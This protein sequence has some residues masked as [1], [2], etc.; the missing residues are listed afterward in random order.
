MATFSRRNWQLCFACASLCA[1][2]AVALA[3]DIPVVRI[4]APDVQ[5]IQ[6]EDDARSLQGRP[7]RYALPNELYLSPDVAGAWDQP[8][9]TTRRWRVRIVS[10]GARSLNFGFD[11]YLMPAG[12]RLRIYATDGSAVLR[13]F[14][15]ADNDMHG[16]LWTPI[17]PSDDVTLEV[18]LPA[19]AVPELALQ[20]A[21]VNVGYRTLGEAARPR[22]QWCEIDVIC[23]EG[24][25]WRD[26]I[27]SVGLVSIGGSIVC[28]G[29][30]VNNTAEDQT[31]YFMTAHHCDLDINNAS[32]LVVYWNFESP[33][34]GQ[35]DGGSLGQWQSGSVWRA[36]YA[37]S[38][39]TLVELDDDPDPD[40]HI[41]FAGWDRSDVAPQTG[42]C[43]HHPDS[44]E[45]SISFE[46]HPCAISS[47]YGYSSPGNGSHIRVNDW[48]LGST[49]S[50]SSGSPL[51]N[52]NH[53]VVGQLHGGVA[54]CNNNE[55]DWYGRFAVSW[56]GGG[57]PTSRLRDWLDPLGTGQMTL[58]T[59]ATGPTRMRV[60]PAI[61]LEGAGYV[62]GPFEP[63]SIVYTVTNLG[64]EP[65]SFNV[66]ANRS[67]VSVSETVGLLAPGGTAPITASI[68][69]N[70]AALPLGTHSATV[71]FTNATSGSGNT[72]RGVVLTVGLSDVRYRFPMDVDPAWTTEGL[73]QFG[74]PAGAYAE[75]GPPDPTSGY[76]GPNV[77]GY[78][79]AGPYEN[80]LPETHLTSTALDCTDLSD[81]RL[82]F[83]RWLGVEQSIYDHAYLRVST[84]GTSFANIWQNS[85]QVFDPGWTYVEYD[86]SAYADGA[87]TLYLRWTMGTTDYGYR[88]CG[89]NIDDV[90]LIATGPNP[91]SGACCL[92]DGACTMTRAA[93]CTG[94]YHGDG[95]LC[96][97]SPC[98]G[99]AVPCYGDCNCSGYVDWRDI[100]FF[101]A[102]Q[103]SNESAWRSLFAPADPTC[104]F[105]NNDVNG[106]GNVDWRDIDPF[107]AVQNLACPVGACCYDTD[108]CRLTDEP[109][110]NDLAGV[111][112]PGQYCSDIACP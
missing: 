101:V 91:P 26:E 25:E 93:D 97:P 36:A 42:V 12:G 63:N 44:D 7:P 68:N 8:D 92:P 78:N 74:Q 84:D 31:P 89:W 61:D 33:T 22:A 5:A 98:P 47:Y 18:T 29:F 71:T 4:P 21:T 9:E 34:C 102:A 55:P 87:P 112:Y 40:W 80:D 60:S 39:F 72:S 96:D 106:D 95:T 57:T 37:F 15:A 69:G 51:F 77:Y 100:D 110:C 94:V 83:W 17:V 73:W 75:L 1:L 76:T 49:E 70:A 28:S 46:H 50:G 64:D 14:T 90:A 53:R 19:A 27:P 58:D 23:P 2:G 20:L 6:R 103:N 82:G 108:Q 67:W 111:F 38:D 66:A 79:L 30:M 99:G 24:D 65:I 32:S 52:A 56:D 109:G 3:G 48:D 88:A 62:G 10:A 16:E 59:L 54:S 85:L 43:I 105:V 11:S 35:Q 45:K 104:P 81:V 107:V 13:P 41:S 86:L